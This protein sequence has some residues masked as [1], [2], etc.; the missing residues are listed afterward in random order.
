MTQ[1]EIH[2]VK[3]VFISTPLFN[4]ISEIKVKNW[5]RRLSKEKSSKIYELVDTWIR[6]IDESI[7]YLGGNEL[8]TDGN[9]DSNGFYS[10][11]IPDEIGTIYYQYIADDFGSKALFVENIEFKLPWNLGVGRLF[12][13]EDKQYN[14]INNLDNII[15]RVIKEEVDST[16]PEAEYCVSHQKFGKS[17]DKKN[18]WTNGKYRRIGKYLI[19]KGDNQPHRIE[20]MELYGENLYDKTMYSAPDETICVFSV[21]K[22]TNKRI[23]FRLEYDK[24]TRMWLGFT[25]LEV[26]DVPVLIRQHIKDKSLNRW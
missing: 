17:C 11:D 9:P 23:C 10:K 14:T 26:K 2:T 15:R 20:G 4:R 21:G 18:A 16:I 7:Q 3:P 24:K 13:I 12:V 8:I 25:P 5:N 1:Y 22:D 19:I 6:R